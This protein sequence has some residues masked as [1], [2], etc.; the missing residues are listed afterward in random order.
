MKL[1]LVN[2]FDKDGPVTNL[3]AG[4]GTLAMSMAIG[5]NEVKCYSL[6]TASSNPE[7]VADEHFDAVV[8]SVTNARLSRLVFD[9]LRKANTRIVLFTDGIY[10]KL[11]YATQADKAPFFKL[12]N[13]ADAILANSD[14]NYWYWQEMVDDP[15][16]VYLIGTPINEQY[17][18]LAWG[19]SGFGKEYDLVWLGYWADRCFQDLFIVAKIVENLGLRSMAAGL[20]Y[21]QLAKYYNEAIESVG[22]SSLEIL[23]DIAPFNYLSEYLR[24]VFVSLYF[25][26][27]AS[28]GRAAAECAV[29]GVPSIGTPSYF[30]VRLFPRLTMPM[31]VPHKLKGMITQLRDDTGFYASIVKE[32]Q[33]KAQEYYIEPFAEKLL[34]ILEG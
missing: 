17:I 30:Q 10:G 22:I 3:N 4:I 5:G 11:E 19:R 9:A 8:I 6:N 12:Y 7:M 24:K 31:L 1:A 29:V 33:E 16:R 2:M 18:Q 25:P 14:M 34:P 27:R 23:K 28:L 20:S 32:A 15:G 13:E 21:N 26:G